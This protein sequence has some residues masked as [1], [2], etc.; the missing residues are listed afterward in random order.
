MAKLA[1]QPLADRLVI[2]RN[3]G[4]DTTSGGIV[5]PDSA[6]EK[7]NRG[8]VLA[9]GDGALDDKGSRIPM[10]VQPGD[11]VLFN[12]HSGEEFT[13]GEASYLLVRESD[14]L[15]ILRD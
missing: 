7:V 10:K 12:K 8:N 6:K 4:E 9:V 15:A 11:Q 14:L 2:Q 1:L 3:E 5:L 13:F